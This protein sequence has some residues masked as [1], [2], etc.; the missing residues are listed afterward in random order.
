M[1]LLSYILGDSEN[2][3]AAVKRAERF[4][5]VLPK[6]WLQSGNVA[7]LK[8][9]SEQMKKLARS[10]ESKRKDGLTGMTPLARRLMR[11]LEHLG[12]SQVAKKL[13]SAYKL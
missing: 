10:L 8:P 1:Q 13:A 6:A 7:L 2:L 4:V 12:E 9:V 3:E 11:A 5:S